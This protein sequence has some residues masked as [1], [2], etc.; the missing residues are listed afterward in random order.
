M[1]GNVSH[2]DYTA[3]VAAL[4]LLEHFGRYGAPKTILTDRGAQ[5]ANEI[6]TKVCET[7][8]T[9][10]HKTPIAHSHE[11]NDKVENANR[12]VLRSIRAIVLD[13]RVMHD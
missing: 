11:H 6:V 2:P 13:E 9:K 3:E 5:F 8:G 4:K 12:Q 10:Y 1:A 7:F